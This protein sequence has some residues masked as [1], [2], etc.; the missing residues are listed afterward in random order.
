MKYFFLVVLFQVFIQSAFAQETVPALWP[1]SGEYPTYRATD[2]FSCGATISP[3]DPRWNFTSAQSSEPPLHN[4]GT[5]L[6]WN[7]TP[8]GSNEVVS[9]YCWKTVSGPYCP[10]G[11]NYVGN[12]LC[13]KKSPC[14]DKFGLY[15][16]GGD[17]QPVQLPGPSGI[18]TGPA[19]DGKVPQ[20]ICIGGCKANP[21]AGYDYVGAVLKDGTYSVQGNPRYN[22]ESCGSQSENPPYSNVQKNTPEYDCLSKGQNYGYVNGSVLCTT[23]SKPSDALGKTTTNTT[24]NADGTKTEVVKSDYV[25]CT[26]AGSCTTTTVTTT[27][28]ISADGTRGTPSTTTSTNTTQGGGGSG[29]PGA[30]AIDKSDPFCVSNPNSPMCKSGSFSG[31]CDA[32]PACDGDPVQCAVAIATWKTDCKTLAPGTPSDDQGP[33]TEKKI[34]QAFSYSDISSGGDCPAPVNLTIAGHQIAIE[35]TP[36]CR[37]AT[38][39]R[40]VVILLAWLAAGYIVLGGN[41]NG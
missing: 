30:P 32:Q 7:Y 8:P 39:L 20:L 24:S 21:R 16:N 36:V 11:Y 10:A 2:S 6:G 26:G 19:V 9:T 33:V 22:G 41:R 35:Y 28:T 3:G 23:P 34:E 27:T 1:T 14:E 17:P 25:N 15:D 5:Y 4:G 31:S 18:Y 37:L 29:A 12:D 38:G 40:P 13:R